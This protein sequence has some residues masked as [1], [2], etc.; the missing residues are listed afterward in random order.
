MSKYTKF[1]FT[2]CDSIYKL[3]TMYIVYVDVH[4]HVNKNLILQADL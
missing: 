4:M 3:Y 1:I 2:Y